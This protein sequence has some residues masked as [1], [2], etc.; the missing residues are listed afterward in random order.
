MFRPDQ[1][2]QLPKGLEQLIR[3][4]HGIASV[5]NLGAKSVKEIQQAF[6]TECYARL[7]P[8]ERAVFWQEVLDANKPDLDNP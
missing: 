2:L 5:R 3:T 6:L 8:Y 1:L 4:E 7:I